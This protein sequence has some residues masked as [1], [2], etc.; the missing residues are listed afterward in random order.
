MYNIHHHLFIDVIETVVCIGESLKNN[1]NGVGSHYFS[2]M[3]RYKD[4]VLLKNTPQQKDLIKWDFKDI[5]KSF[6]LLVRQTRS[7]YVYRL[8]YKI[9]IHLTDQICCNTFFIFS[10]VL[11]Q[12]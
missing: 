8:S 10:E 2:G 3:D 12:T 5:Y 1:G 7:L 4:F 9:S 6:F 11:S